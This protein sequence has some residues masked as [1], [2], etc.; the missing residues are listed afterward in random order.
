MIARAPSAAIIDGRMAPSMLQLR[1][2]HTHVEALPAQIA[3]AR[4]AFDRLAYLKL[5]A[6]LEPALLQSLLDELDRTEFYHRVHDG[7]GTE[8]CARPGVVSGALELLMNDTAL[9]QVI[10]DVTGCG[11]IGC[12]EGRIYR[13]VPGT[14]H[15]DSWHSD[16]G[17]DRLI[18][19]SINLGRAAPAGGQLQIRKALTDQILSEVYNPISGDAVIFRVDPS[20]QHRVEPVVGDVPR[21]VYAGWF[22]AKPE[23]AELLLQKLGR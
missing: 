7:I 21:T 14:D 19:L 9:Q 6:F 11:H 16:V 13:M 1:P 17:Q 12:F 4:D 3:E 5:P 10:S 23:F 22:R 18:A 8:L 20:M 15:H 2:Q